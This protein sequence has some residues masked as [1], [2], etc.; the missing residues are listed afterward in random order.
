M[1]T[2]TFLREKDLVG[3]PGE[4]GLVGFSRSTLWRRVADGTFPSPIKLSPGVTAWRHSDVLEWIADPTAYLTK[5]SNF[6]Q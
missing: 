4:H 3:R 6:L 2:P 1:D 5:S